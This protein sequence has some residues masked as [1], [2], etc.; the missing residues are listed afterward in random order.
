MAK[1]TRKNRRVIPWSEITTIE[2]TTDMLKQFGQMMVDAIVKEAK[3]DF[4]KQR[5]SG[6]GLQGLPDS[7]NFF[8]SFSYQIKGGRVDIVSDWPWIEDLTEG[9]DSFKMIWLTQK[10]GINKVPLIQ[11][12]GRV[13][14]RSAPISTANAWI[15]PGI[16][17]HT[18]IKRGVKKAKA[19]FAPVLMT[20]L[21]QMMF[22]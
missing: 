9:K 2:I 15:H 21:K 1:L 17:K 20:K 16:A 10:R 4:A 5:K 11:K 13:I 8:K 18:F 22:G 6:K 3:I 12:D 14:I 7:P 19:E